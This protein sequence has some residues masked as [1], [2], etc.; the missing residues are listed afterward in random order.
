MFRT[1]SAFWKETSTA[2]QTNS[3]PTSLN[4]SDS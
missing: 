1:S 4:S 2:V 3:S